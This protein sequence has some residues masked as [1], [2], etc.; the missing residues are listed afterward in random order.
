M[1]KNYDNLIMAL[2]PNKT[3]LRLGLHI[4]FTKYLEDGAPCFTKVTE[5]NNNNFDH[6]VVWDKNGKK[7][8]KEVVTNSEK[9][10]SKKKT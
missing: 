8:G 1:A 6:K 7:D 2:I 10:A 3:L 4:L 5:H 9:E